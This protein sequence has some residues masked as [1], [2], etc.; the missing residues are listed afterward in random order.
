MYDYIE[1]VCTYKYPIKLT[2]KSGS[3][4][5]GISLD[6]AINEQRMECIKLDTNGVTSLVVLADIAVL[7][8][9]VEN[10]HFSS[11]SFV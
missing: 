1:I 3:I 11:I 9:C 4:I 10:P 5:E 8:V 6:T 2:L 7:E